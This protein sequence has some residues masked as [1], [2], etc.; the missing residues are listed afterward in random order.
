MTKSKRGTGERRNVGSSKSEDGPHPKSDDAASLIAAVRSIWGAQADELDR[1]LLITQRDLETTDRPNAMQLRYC[2]D[3]I[4]FAFSGGVELSLKV[5]GVDSN[6]QGA[7]LVDAL[8]S[9]SRISLPDRPSASHFTFIQGGRVAL[10]GVLM[11]RPMRRLVAWDL[12]HL[13]SHL[14]SSRA[15]LSDSRFAEKTFQELLVKF[16]IERLGVNRG[17]IGR[18]DR[19]RGD[20]REARQ[21]AGDDFMDELSVATTDL[22]ADKEFWDG[23]SPAVPPWRFLW[24]AGQ[25]AE[26]TVHAG[27]D[28][29]PGHLAERVLTELA[30]RG[31][32]AIWRLDEDGKKYQEPLLG[33]SELETAG[34]VAEAD[35]LED[36]VVGKVEHE[37]LLEIL[38]A[39]PDFDLWW[40]QFHE[41][42]TQHQI[43]ARV[44]VSQ[45]RV[46]QRITQFKAAARNRFPAFR[47]K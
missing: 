14:G 13:F 44:G 16:F 4:E 26:F 36:Q 22:T 46:S 9:G 43:A 5:D 30:N 19:L 7:T 35:S 31:G 45:A 25:P 18:R 6:L 37:E 28:S 11:S 10:N 17:P 42:L 47:P 3:N 23:V 12:Q 33:K 39:I 2:D 15:P 38:R 20:L 29:L 41:R 1:Q 27:R 24:V 32:Q 21:I 40:M 34:A 8:S